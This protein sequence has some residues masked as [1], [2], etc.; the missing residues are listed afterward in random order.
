[1]R[2]L[3]LI[4]IIVI[5]NA[6]TLDNL[7][8]Y[9]AQQAYK[10]GNYQKALKK[11]KSLNQNYKITFEIANTLYRLNRFKEAISYYQMV[12]HPSLQGEIYFNI[13]NCYYKMRQYNKA[14]IFYKN[15]SKFK[16]IKIK[17]LK[18]LKISKKLAKINNSKGKNKRGKKRANLE[19]FSDP[20]VSKN[21][22]TAKLNNQD[23]ANAINAK[24]IKRVSKIELL[25]EKNNTK[26]SDKLYSLDKLKKDRINRALE[27]KE[28]KTLL[29]PIDFSQKI[30]PSKSLILK[31][32]ND[33]SN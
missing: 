4:F 23:A 16:D 22:K 18:N 19:D 28:R 8:H 3:L 13:A 12:N 1:M 2:Y 27:E 10:N 6:N 29:I 25:K 24:L 26:K 11:F 7:Q 32:S 20:F 14:N 5:L 21:L 31:D 30:N 15:A 17:A 9:L 33:K